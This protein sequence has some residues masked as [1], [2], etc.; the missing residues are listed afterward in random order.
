MVANVK[1]YVSVEMICDNCG[2]V[3]P[4]SII[5]DDGKRYIIDKVTDV[6][7]SASKKVGGMGIRYTCIIG[8]REKFL[9]WEDPKWFVEAIENRKKVDYKCEDMMIEKYFG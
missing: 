5:W 4:L 9:F 8:G 1:K 6:R 7:M 2:M 3:Q